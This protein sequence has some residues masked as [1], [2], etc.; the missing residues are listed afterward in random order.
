M[1]GEND[2]PTA[3]PPAAESPEGRAAEAAGAVD[4]RD[5]VDGESAGGSIEPE[6][7]DNQPAAAAAPPEE[8][9]PAK[10]GGDDPKPPPDPRE[11]IYKNAAAQRDRELAEVSED[12]QVKQ[13]DRYAG[14]AQPETQDEPDDDAAKAGA[15][16]TREAPA[17]E[18]PASAGVRLQVYGEE[19]EVSH[20]DVMQA[21]IQTLQKERAAEYRLKQAADAERALRQYRKELD[22]Y[23]ERLLA[24]AQG[25]QTDQPDPE[26]TAPPKSGATV[27]Q[28]SEKIAEKANA[29]AEA[30]YRGD[31]AEVS[32]ALTE[33]LA[34]VAQGR[35]ATPPTADVN[36][37]V[38]TA[39]QRRQEQE[40]A[41][42]REET[43]KAVNRTFNEEFSDVSNDAEAFAVAQ[44][45]FK[46]MLAD[47]ENEGKSQVEI[48]RLA[49]DH[50]RKRLHL[51]PPGS[52]GGTGQQPATAS[53][54]KKASDELA[55]RREVKRTIVHSRPTSQRMP[56]PQPK[57]FPTNKEYVARLREGRGQAP[58]G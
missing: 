5:I 39:L 36:E 37:V 4:R 52:G 27:T 48:A 38:E 26:K 21:G 12:D 14:A 9:E 3:E 17:G 25:R 45:R 43:R 58:L 16:D 19:I 2:L 20:D 57:Q 13:L 29:V 18:A 30:I 28:D 7:P 49:G 40:E 41:A 10:E 24:K 44:A 6:G 31:S 50:A 33:L 15:S 35:T 8:G 11:A 32:K 42:R 55:E 46:A 53:G 34:G 47:P 1:A 23:R 56:A 22:E 51:Q 54:G